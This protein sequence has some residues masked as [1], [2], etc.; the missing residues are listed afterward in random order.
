MQRVIGRNYARVRMAP[1]DGTGHG[2]RGGGS[3]RGGG[4]GGYA[5][6]AGPG[7]DHRVPLGRLDRADLAA[8]QPAD[9]ER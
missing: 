3:V 5:R 1:A 8:G 9:G 2:D 4:G 6:G 7:R